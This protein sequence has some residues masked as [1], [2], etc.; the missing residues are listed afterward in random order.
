MLEFN[1]SLFGLYVFR[2]ATGESMR[3]LDIFD[4]RMG[5]DGSGRML[6]QDKWATF[7]ALIVF[8]LIGWGIWAFVHRSQPMMD[9]DAD[10]VNTRIPN[11]EMFK[12]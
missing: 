8:V 12:P 9:Q 6:R 2:T 4:D 7:V 11:S 10:P 5:D 1:K 3:V